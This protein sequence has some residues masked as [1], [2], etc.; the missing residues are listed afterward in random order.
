MI[1]FSFD[2]VFVG[3]DNVLAL[4]IAAFRASMMGKLGFS[5]V[6]AGT[7]DRCIDFL[8]GASFVPL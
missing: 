4:V 7:D 8:V 2:L 3:N 6:R 1:G 5:T